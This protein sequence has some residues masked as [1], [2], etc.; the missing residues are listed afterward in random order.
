MPKIVF[1]DKEYL[2]KDGETVLDCLIR[3]GAQVEYSCQSGVCQTCMLKAVSG[4]PGPDSQP[5]LK[6][7]LKAQHYFLACSCIPEGDMEIVRP[8]DALMHVT[9][10]VQSMDELN[11]EVVRLRLARPEGYTYFPGQFLNLF[12]ADGVGRS[13]SLASLAEGEDFLELHIRLLPKG[14]VSGWV[15]SQ[16]AVGDTVTISHAIGDCFYTRGA[17]EQPLLLV[18]TGTGL[19]PLYGVL[20][21]A[22]RQAHSGDIHL[23]HGASTPEGLY[24]I[25]ALG[26]L[27]A[28]AENVFY[29]PCVSQ[30]DVP[31]GF[32]SGRADQLALA[33]HA[34]LSGWQVYLCGREEM[35]KATQRNAYLAGAGLKDIHADAFLPAP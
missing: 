1:E 11:P 22:L 17:P 10:V 8:G 31:E 23:Y 30:G 13:Y 5:D 35:V 15:H 33:E 28:E 4:D 19:A 2:T 9:T 32:T 16:L 18:G 34:D 14:K 3:Q 12:N 6:D 20:R 24:L 21:D 29:H 7:A 25:E 27:A 26:T